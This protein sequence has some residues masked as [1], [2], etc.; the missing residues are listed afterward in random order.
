MYC[1]VVALDCFLLGKHNHYTGVQYVCVLSS[2]LTVGRLPDDGEE[3][4]VLWCVLVEDAEGRVGDDDSRVFLHVDAADRHHRLSFLFTLLR[5]EKQT[6]SEVDWINNICDMT[7]S[8]ET[9]ICNLHVKS[10]FYSFV[11]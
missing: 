2:V 9:M 7:K 3:D 4:L 11:Y 10:H 6:A 8:R 1:G 5:K